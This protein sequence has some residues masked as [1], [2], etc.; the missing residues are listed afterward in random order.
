MH[1]CAGQQ[2]PSPRRMW[3]R[4]IHVIDCEGSHWMHHSWAYLQFQP[5]KDRFGLGT[6]WGWPGDGLGTRRSQGVGPTMPRGWHHRQARPGCLV[7]KHKPGSQQGSGY[8]GGAQTGSR[9]GVKTPLPVVQT[10]PQLMPMEVRRT[11]GSPLPARHRLLFAAPGRYKKAG[12]DALTCIGCRVP[13][14]VG[15]CSPLM[16]APCPSSH[17]KQAQPL[18]VMNV[19]H[20]AV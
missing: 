1:A 13:V 8:Q 11:P 2:R 5:V 17:F 19:A 4:E 15:A 14:Q 10:L 12:M 9:I 20:S 16:A 3:K 18:T 7:D 6:C